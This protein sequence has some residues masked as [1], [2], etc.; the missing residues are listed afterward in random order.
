MLQVTSD[1]LEVRQWVEDRGGHPCREPKT[2]RL[3]IDLPG[4]PCGDVLV[5]WEE[6]EP[7]FLVNHLTFVFDTD[8][9]GTRWFIG[10]PEQAR[11]Y[12][13]GEQGVSKLASMDYGNLM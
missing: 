1:I 8:P 4:R 5:G 11:A 12:L 3:S 2:G 10:P 6:F 7:A 9:K 13:A